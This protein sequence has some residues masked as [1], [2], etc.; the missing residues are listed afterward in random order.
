MIS[1][2]HKHSPR[3]K[4]FLEHIESFSMSA[5]YM[6]KIRMFPEFISISDF[7]IS[8]VIVIIIFKRMVEYMF[9]SSKFIGKAVI[10]PVLIGKKNKFLFFNK[11]N[12]ESI[13]EYL[14][15]S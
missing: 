12:R 15:Q 11:R 9:V 1:K 8:E 13:S 4:K 3:I 6:F 14:V 2:N 7:N 10:T 5:S